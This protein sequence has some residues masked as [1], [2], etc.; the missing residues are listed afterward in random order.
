MAFLQRGVNGGG[1][2]ERE[3]GLGRGRVDLYVA[4][5]VSMVI[6]QRIVIEMKIIRSPREKTIQDGLDQVFKYVDQSRTDK[7]HLIIFDQTPGFPGM[8]KNSGERKNI[9]GHQAGIVHCRSRYGG[10]NIE[11]FLRITFRSSP[12]R[13]PQILWKVWRQAEYSPN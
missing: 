6:W 4:W 8:K 10:C 9:P 11:V 3:Y 13:E 2:I 12:V 5:P 1:W 7:A